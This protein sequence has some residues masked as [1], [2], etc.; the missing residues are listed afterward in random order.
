MAFVLDYS[1]N[2]SFFSVPATVTTIAVHMWGGGGG[3]NGGAGAFLLGTLDVTPGETLRLI[4]GCGACTPGLDAQGGGGQGMGYTSYAPSLVYAQGGGRSSIQRCLS[5]YCAPYAPTVVG[6]S[7]WQEIVTAGGGGAGLSQ[8][9]Y[10]SW[11][12]VTAVR[13][14]DFA[15]SS[16]VRVA[17]Y[18]CG[19]G[20]A[21]MTT[22]GG[23]SGAQFTGGTGAAGGG[24]GWFGG[25]TSSW[26]YC[27]DIFGLAAGSGSSNPLVLRNVA[28]R[29]AFPSA[30][31]ASPGSDISA[32]YS[33]SIGIGGTN[34][35]GG[36]GRAVIQ[37][38]CSGCT[39]NA[40][41]TNCGV[42]RYYPSGGPSC[43]SSATATGTSR[44]TATTT[45]SASVTASA[46]PRIYSLGSGYF[47]V[48]PAGAMGVSTKSPCTPDPASGPSDTAFYWSGSSSEGS[49]AFLVTASSGISYV[50]DRYSAV[51]G[52]V[53]LSAGSSLSTSPG[54]VSAL[55]VGNAAFSLAEWVLCP[56]TAASSSVL[57]LSGGGQQAVLLVSGRDTTRCVSTLAGSGSASFSDGLGTA[58]SFNNLNGV[59]VHSSGTVYV[60][61]TNINRIRAINAAGAVST[62]S[63]SGSASFSDG[64]GTAA[65][66]KSPTGVAVD[67]SGTMYVADSGNNRIRKITPGGV[68]TTLSGS[69]SASFSDGLGT[70]AS[71][72]T[73]TGVAV[74]SSGTVYV[75]DNNNHRIRAITPAGAVS[76]F[77]GSGVYG[78]SNGLGPAASFAYPAGVAVDSSGTVYVADFYNHRIRAITPGGIVS[79]LAGSGY[80]NGDGL[81][82]AARFQFPRGVSTAAAVYT[83]LTCKTVLSAQL[84]LGVS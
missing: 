38:A 3:G 15:A 32:Y 19:G 13:G 43:T 51:G 77:A 16:S 42:A 59:T 40:M 71:F 49:R 14:M 74:D 39:C 17:S 31:K 36:P 69:G 11:D 2:Y 50:A 72:K 70:A 48:C 84:P 63:G 26:N 28:G 23:P 65:S 54:A 21:T 58:A 79:T 18:N 46:M 7:S 82:T 47:S 27:W 76:T 10:A 78:F 57:Q 56:S 34:S 5:S 22:A 66:F 73:T 29:S 6:G 37:F 62:F 1:G 8:G 45:P 35:V 25:G 81:G 80:G 52:A 41:C 4:V 75:A 33:A 53:S 9:A 20:G 60:V 68:V 67:S 61:D 24:G 44:A 30:P 12:G 83:W 64:L 55:P